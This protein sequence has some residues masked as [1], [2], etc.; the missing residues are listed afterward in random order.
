[1]VELTYKKKHHQKLQKKQLLYLYMAFLA[2]LSISVFLMP[3]GI[4]I[5]DKTKILTYLSGTMFWVGFVGTICIALYITYL[6][7]RSKAFA[8]EKSIHKRLGIILF[9]QNRPAIISDV[10]LFVALIGFIITRVL[11]ETTVFPFLFLSLFI[12][13][14]GMHCM[15]NGSNYNYI[16]YQTRSVTES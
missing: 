16:K 12:F 9:F 10:L 6:R 13:S 14:F 7:R 15:L 2:V 5:A 1:M 11:S 3:M 4:K 8:D